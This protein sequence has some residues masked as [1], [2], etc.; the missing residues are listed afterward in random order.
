LPSERLIAALNQQVARHYAA[1]HQYVA[2]GAY[3]DGETFPRLARFFYKRAKEQRA[4]ATRIVDYLL[5]VGSPVTLGEVPAPRSSFEAHVEPIQAALQQERRTT[6]EI[7][8]LFEIARETRDPASEVFLQRSVE[9]QVEEETRME[10]LLQVAER[11]REFPTML[12]EFIARDG[13]RLGT[14][15]G[16]AAG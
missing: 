7:G 16:R 8:N 6:V 5:E 3:Y 4:H 12:E 10:S 13:K 1:A 9:K 11:V 2:I 14:A 15:R